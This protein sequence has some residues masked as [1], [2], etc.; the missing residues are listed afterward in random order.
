MKYYKN[1]VQ[2]AYDNCIFCNHYFYTRRQRKTNFWL[3]LFFI[4][5]NQ[6][7]TEPSSQT[8]QLLLKLQVKTNNQYKIKPI[9]KSTKINLDVRRP[10]LRLSKNIKYKKNSNFSKQNITFNYEIHSTSQIKRYI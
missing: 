3:F 6:I 4:T 7:Q 5:H 10:N 9:Q 2:T 8:T 1:S